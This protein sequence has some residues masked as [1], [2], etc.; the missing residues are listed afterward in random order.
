[1]SWIATIFLL[2]SIALSNGNDKF[3]IYD[4][5]DLVNRYANNTDRSH[6]DHGKI[7]RKNIIGL[8]AKLRTAVVPGQVLSS[9]T[10][11]ATLELE[12][13]LILRIL[14]IKLAS[15]HCSRLSTN[16]H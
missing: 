14:S 11:L 15:S 10:G 8:P 4:W 13:L 16:V 2:C 5:P 6:R 9:L 7:D 12:G 3:F 1:M